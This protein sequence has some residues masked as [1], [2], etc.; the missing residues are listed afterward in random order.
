MYDICEESEDSV[1]CTTVSKVCSVNTYVA[2]CQ[3]CSV[4]H[5]VYTI[6][7]LHHEVVAHALQNREYH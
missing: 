7:E 6:C 2:D 4:F 3:W 1:K 5:C